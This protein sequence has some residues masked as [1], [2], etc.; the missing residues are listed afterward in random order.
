MSN[1]AVL[2]IQNVRK[3]YTMG[4]QHVLVL[5]GVSFD[6]PPGQFLSI[7]G[8]S[9]CGK[10]TLMNLIGCLDRADSGDVRIDGVAVNTV[11]DDG[12]AH[13]RNQKIGFVFQ[14][15]NLIPRLTA[16]EN[17][18]I[19]LIYAGVDPETRRAR[20]KEMLKRMGLGDRTHHRPNELSGGQLQR[21][22]IARSL[23]NDPSILLADEPTG[24]LDSKSGDEIVAIFHDLNIAGM[25]IIMV[26]HNPELASATSR[27][28]H[29]KDGV[30]TQDEVT[31]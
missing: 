17:V 10:S 18:T 14:V 20:A 13:L 9:G 7:M 16:L 28:M 21:V 25:T 15:F 31:R 4:N 19:P 1:K 29:M 22:A 8:P 2:E 3:S 6:V 11:D 30:I 26:T 5:H 27:I 23:M 24:N 12:L